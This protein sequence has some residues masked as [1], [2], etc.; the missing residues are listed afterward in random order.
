[1]K[2]SVLTAAVYAVT[3][4]QATCYCYNT[5]VSN[6]RPYHSVILRSDDATRYACQ[7]WGYEPVSGSGGLVCHG[8]TGLSLAN[9]KAACNK[10]G[11][12]EATC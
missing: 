10:Y 2:L 6:K 4:V 9:W 1:M 12:K 8:A 3:S 11:A 7:H 5:A